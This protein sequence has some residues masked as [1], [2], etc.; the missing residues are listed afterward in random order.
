MAF[1]VSLKTASLKMSTLE[2]FSALIILELDF[3]LGTILPWRLREMSK[4]HF[5]PSRSLE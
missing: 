5:S 4:A 3:V 1:N 2:H